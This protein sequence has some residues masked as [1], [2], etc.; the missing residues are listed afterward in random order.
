[1]NSSEQKLVQQIFQY[2][3]TE[4][5]KIRT[6][7]SCTGGS[8]ASLFTTLPGSSDFFDRGIVTYSNKAKEELL[9]ISPEILERYGAVSYETAMLMVENLVKQNT[10]GIATTGILGPD[11]N[12]TNKPVG[13]VYISTHLN[14]KTNI[15][16]LSLFGTRDNIKEQ[17]ITEALKLCLSSLQD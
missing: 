15:K 11:S 16:K 1:M 6:A 2:C 9:N 12:N 7:E 4:N 5:I 10:I 13:L 14:Q 8:I 17:V 3:K